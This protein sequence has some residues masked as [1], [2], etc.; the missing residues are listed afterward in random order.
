[1]KT[2]PVTLLVVLLLVNLCRPPT[3][4][5]FLLATEQVGSQP[6]VLYTIYLPVLQRREG[7]TPSQSGLVETVLKAL[8]QLLALPTSLRIKPSV[9]GR[10][11]VRGHPLR[12]PFLAD[13]V[14]PGSLIRLAVRQVDF[15]RVAACPLVPF[16]ICLTLLRVLPLGD[17]AE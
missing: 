15:L 13:L 10:Q 17:L 8:I 5:T 12:V 14:H 11:L 6:T 7:I 1:M 16:L 2:W 9:V 4:T 3:L